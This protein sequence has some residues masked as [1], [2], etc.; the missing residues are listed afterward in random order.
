[1][2]RRA[3]QSKICMAENFGFSR[4]E[5]VPTGNCVGR[6]IAAKIAGNCDNPD[7]S[8]RQWHTNQQR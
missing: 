5:F 7:L 6:E 1:V 2:S 4:P 8:S 3:L